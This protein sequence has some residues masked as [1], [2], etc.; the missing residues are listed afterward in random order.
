MDH[1]ESDVA[2]ASDR[3]TLR[4]ES[5]TEWIIVATP[6]L[7]TRTQVPFYYTSIVM[8]GYI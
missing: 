8:L 3:Q 1:S 2:T 7:S 4:I 5:G 6:T